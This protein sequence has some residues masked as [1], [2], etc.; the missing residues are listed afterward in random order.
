VTSSNI[1]N[2]KTSIGLID[3][4]PFAPSLFTAN[5]DG[6]G[7][8][9]A[10]LLRVRAD[11]SQSYEPVVRFDSA[12]NRSVAVPIEFG[13]ANDQLFL[14]LYGTGLR[15]HKGGAAAAKLGGVNSAVQFVGT[16]NGFAGLD[17][18][19]LEL[20]RSLSGRGEIELELTIDGR[21]ANMVRIVI[22]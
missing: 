1:G 14:L 7:L 20:P 19:N 21:T 9:A 22:R 6:K 12:L 5:A 10:V 8:A 15:H 11:G 2:G 16:V 4:A 13:E 18:V 17:Q 3:V